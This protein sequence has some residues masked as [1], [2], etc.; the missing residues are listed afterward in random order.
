MLD[1]ITLK[2]SPKEGVHTEGAKGGELIVRDN[3]ILW[4]QKGRESLPLHPYP[5]SCS[6]SACDLHAPHDT[7]CGKSL[8]AHTYQKWHL[9]EKGLY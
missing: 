3:D 9:R 2:V 6:R 1:H 8:R 5:Q 7:Q 4:D